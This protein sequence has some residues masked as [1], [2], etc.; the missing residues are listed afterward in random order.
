MWMTEFSVTYMFCSCVK[1]GFSNTV[2][3]VLYYVPKV[4]RLL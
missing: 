3:T 2:Y 1:L 4:D